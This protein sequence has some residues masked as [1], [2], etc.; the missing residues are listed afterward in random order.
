ML[1]RVAD[2]LYW[3]GRYLERAEHTARL[4]GVGL[5]LMLDQTPESV[6]VRWKRLLAALRTPLSPEAANDPTPSLAH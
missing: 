6:E 2:G 3:M 5:N 1:S 4:I